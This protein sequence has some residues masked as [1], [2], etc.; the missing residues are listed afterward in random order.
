MNVYKVDN[1]EC[2]ICGY[3]TDNHQSF[4]SHIAHAH[5]IK[6]KEYYDRYIKSEDEGKCKKCGKQTSFINMWKGYRD[7]CCNSC[8]SS[9]KEIQDRRKQ[10]SLEHYGV[11]FPH[12]SQEVKDNMEKTCLSRYGATNVY[13]S[14]YGKQKI[15]E[16]NLERYGAENPWS[17]GSSIIHK[18]QDTYEKLTGYRY[19][20][21][22]RDARIKGYKTK[23]KNGHRSS[24]ETKLEQFFIDNNINYEIE[25]NLD[26]RYPYFCDFYLPETDIFIE[27]HGF[28]QHGGHWFDENNPDDIKKVNYWKSKTSKQYK[29]AIISWT[30]YDLL[31]RQTAIDNNLNYVVLWNETDIDN[32]INTVNK[33]SN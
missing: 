1:V 16:T 33:H 28:W 18:S 12:Q 9:S 6:S 29:S 25:Y 15:K 27:I 24:L 11:E 31:K 30:K 5:H 22:N 2:V 13:T 32:F 10:T 21:Q 19:P 14:E 3:N 8:M 20:G 26:P 23:S 7:Y 17:H 4:N